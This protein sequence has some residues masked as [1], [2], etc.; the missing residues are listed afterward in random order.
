MYDAYVEE[1]YLA[2]PEDT[3]QTVGRLAREAGLSSEMEPSWLAQ[4]AVRFVQE[5][6]RYDSQTPYQPENEDF[7]VYFLTHSQRGYCVHFASAVTVTLRAMGV[8]ARYV[9]GYLV[10]VKNGQADVKDE[11]A[12]AWVEY[13]E[14]GV[15]WIP[16][17][18]TP[19]YSQNVL[20]TNQSQIVCLDLSRSHR[21]LPIRKI[22]PLA[23]RSE[24][25][26]PA[27]VLRRS[28]KPKR[29]AG[30]P[31]RELLTVLLV[32]F[33]QWSWVGFDAN[34]FFDSAI[35]DKIKKTAAAHRLPFGNNWG[36]LL[37]NRP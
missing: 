8:P 2:L 33:E 29:A 12:H 16:I 3:A 13:Y 26:S 1:N 34:G 25:G 35:R 5:D 7:V 24:I 15:G 20:Q 11:N 27:R 23:G 4:E 6:K 17:E 14:A 30:N 31:W 9:N 10:T 36:E 32:V 18:A 19:G 21:R 28:H 22:P 37:Q